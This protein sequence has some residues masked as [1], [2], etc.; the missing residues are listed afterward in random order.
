MKFRFFREKFFCQ[1]KNKAFSLLEVLVY[2]A[3]FAVVTTAIASFV[4]WAINAKAKTKAMREVSH[5]SERAMEIIAYEVREAEAIYEPTTNN[6]QLS[7][8]IKKH[9]PTGEAISYIDFFLCGDRLCSKKE[10]RDPVALTSEKIEITNL[11]FTKIFTSSAP[12]IQIELQAN[13][14]NP[15]DL[16]KYKAIADLRTTVAL[17]TY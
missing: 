16:L 9:L 11:N 15:S 3:V 6:N 5:N 14:K 12:S 17:R 13:Y 2:V 8:R 4:L 10:G 1:K 7:L